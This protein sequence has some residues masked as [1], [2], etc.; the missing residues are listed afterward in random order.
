MPRYECRDHPL[1][2]WDELA[3]EYDTPEDA[4]EAYAVAIGLER[5]DRQRAEVEVREVGTDSAPRKFT[6][7]V[8]W[9][10]IFHVEEIT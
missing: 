4:A 2:R 9:S 1:C 10:P 7:E 3:D 6:V 5:D 8:E